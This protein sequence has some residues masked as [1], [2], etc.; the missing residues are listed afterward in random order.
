MNLL[1]VE[2]FI[3]FSDFNIEMAYLQ[4]R[5]AYN[6]KTTRP[7]GVIFDRQLLCDE[8]SVRTNL[9]RDPING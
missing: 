4:T 1:T 5:N 7:I 6:S 9:S 8:V 3:P 2:R